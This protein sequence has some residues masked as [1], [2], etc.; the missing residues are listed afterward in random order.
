MTMTHR[1]GVSHAWPLRLQTLLFLFLSSSLPVATQRQM[2]HLQPFFFLCNYHGQ[3]QNFGLDSGQVVLSVNIEGNPI[4]YKPDTFYNVSISSSETFDSLLMTGLYT[5][6]SSISNSRSSSVTQGSHD[7]MCSIIHSQVSPRPMKTLSFIW[8]APP[9]GTGC[10][11][12][13]ATATHGQQLL[14]KD[15][16]IAQLCEQGAASPT[17][18]HPELAEVNTDSVLIRDDFDSDPDFNPNLWSTVQGGRVGD[19]CGHPVSGNSAIFCDSVGTRKMVS[20]PLNLTSAHML[21]FFLGEGSCRPAS[22]SD[23]DIII[24]YGINGCSRWIPIQTIKAAT[25]SKSEIHLVTLP[26]KARLVGTC[27]MFFQPSSNTG[28]HNPFLTTQNPTVKSAAPTTTLLSGPTDITTQTTPTLPTTAA[29]TTET[30][31]V[32]TKAATESATKQI[33]AIVPS[34]LSSA[35]MISATSSATMISATSSATT[36]SATS[37]ATTISATSPATTISATS[38][39]T[40]TSAK[41]TSV[42]TADST[43]ATSTTR[44][45]THTRA[46]T[47]TPI[48][49]E[50]GPTD[51][52]DI[53]ALL[54]GLP[55]VQPNDRQ[56]AA[57]P[58]ND[59]HACWTMDNVVIVNTAEPP[60]TLQENFDPIDPSDWLFFPG[61]QID[62]QCQAHG[63]ALI[64]NDRN[65]TS[66][67]AT[68]RDLNLDAQD[69]QGNA[70]LF[71][72]FDTGNTKL[73]IEG[74]HLGSSCGII[75]H[76]EA[77]ILDGPK[78]RRVCTDMFDI[79]DVDSAR[80][81][82]KFGGGPGCQADRQSPP[83][84]M[85]LEDEHDSTFMLD[86]L[87]AHAYLAHADLV[88]RTLVNST[89]RLRVHKKARF[90]LLQK[91]HAGRH[92]DVW[93]VDDIAL[94]P[95]LPL[96]S[97]PDADKVFQASLN[98]NCGSSNGGNKSPSIS[99][100]YSTD[101]GATW[102]EFYSPCL[103]FT[104]RNGQYNTLSSYLSGKDIYG[105][106][107][108][109]LPIPYSG[110]SPHSRF[111][112]R[113]HGSPAGQWALDDVFIGP[114]SKWCN[115]HGMCTESGCS[116]DYGYE[117]PVCEHTTSPAPATLQEAFEDSSVTSASSMLDIIGGSVSYLCGVVASGKAIVFNDAGR[118]SLTTTEI[119]T[120]SVSHV[121]FTL[122]VG[123]QSVT[124]SCPPPD[125]PWES[126]LLEMS[127]DGGITWALLGQYHTADYNRPMSL[128]TPIPDNLKRLCQFRW[129]QP[130]HSGQDK[131]VWAI[132]DILLLSLQ[133]AG[134]GFD[135]NTPSETVDGIERSVTSLAVEMMNSPDLDKRLTA[136]L[137]K[138]EDSF[139]GRM[140]SLKFSS[141]ERNG[142]PRTLQTKALRVGPGYIAQFDLVMGCGVPYNGHLDNRIYFQYSV[143]HGIS[144]HLVEDIC[145]PP[146]V[147]DTYT[148][149]SIY[150]HTKY[151]TWQT[152]SIWLSPTTWSQ[153]TKFQWIQPDWSETDVW[154]VSRVYI[155]HPCL[156]LCHGH[157][158]C[159]LGACSCHDGF[160]GESCTPQ[161]KL[162]SSIHADFGHRYDPKM[163]FTIRGGE[164]I[165]AD[166]GC[167][168]IL[169]GESLL[170]DKDG[171]RELLTKDMN[172][173]LVDFLQFWIQIG[174]ESSGSDRGGGNVI[175]GDG[176]RCSGADRR[177]ESIL[178]RYSNDGGIRWTL[179]A[180]LHH[181][182]YRTPSFVH[183]PLPEKAKSKHTRFQLWQPEH[184]GQG[185]DHWAVDEI[186]FGNYSK[187]HTLEDDF[188][189]YLDPIQSGQWRVITDGAT[190]K[191]CGRLQPSLVMSNQVNR[192]L[193]ISKDVQLKPGNV[194]Q[195]EINVD[196]GKLY[197]WN[198]PVILQYSH[199]NGHTWS[200]VEDPCYMDQECDGKLTEGSIYY[201][202]TH[203]Q[204][205]LVV[206]PISD[207]IAM[208][209]AIFQWWQQGGVD[210]SFSLDNVYIGPQCP[211]NCNRRGVCSHGV[212]HCL[213]VQEDGAEVSGPDCAPSGVTPQGMLDRFD[214][215]NMPLMEFWQHIRSGHLGRGCGVV[216]LGD[217]LY[218]GGD[219]T[220][221][222]Q[223][224]QLNTTEKRILEVSIKIGADRFSATCRPAS[225]RE[226]AVIIDF[227]RDN[228]ISWSV[229]RVVQ[230]S[231]EDV[232]SA[233]I[234]VNLP[235]EAKSDRTIF[236]FWQPL[237]L[238]GMPRAE[239]AIDSVLV[240]VNETSRPGF[241]DKFAEMMPSRY[242][243]FLA[244]AASNRETCGSPDSAL[245]FSHKDGYHIAETWDYQVTPTTFL[246]F[247]LALN[248]GA[249]THELY[250]IA[251]EYSIDH[252]Q[253]WFPVLSACTPPNYECAGYHLS[254]AYPSAYYGN[255]TRVTVA[256]PEGTVSPKT[257]FRWRRSG[258][259]EPTPIWAIDNVYLGSDCPWLC[260][261][262]GVCDQGK[263]LCDQ[264]FGGEICVSIT[265]LPATLKD[266]FDSM[267][268][269]PTIWGEVHGG[270][271]S[272]LCGAVVT[273]KSLTFQKNGL[274]IAVTHDMDSTLV[275]HIEFHFR[276]GCGGEADPWPRKHSVLLQY[277]TTGGILWKL[278]REIYFSNTS[279]PVFYSIPLPPG[280]KHN[281]TRF[282]FWQASS[283]G[284]QS[285]VWALD[286]LYIGPMFV[287]PPSLFDTFQ[288]GSPQNDQPGDP[289]AWIFVNNGQIDQFCDSHRRSYLSLGMG[290][291]SALVFRRYNQGQ[292]SAITTDLDL[293]PNSVLQFDINVG[294]GTAPRAKY[295]V[296]LEYSADGGSSWDLLGP[297]CV[298]EAKFAH[299]QKS[300]SVAASCFESYLPSTVF[301]A[302][303][304]SYWRRVVVPLNHIRVCGPVRFRWYQGKIPDT[305]FG[306][307][308]AID[309]VY[310]GPSCLEHCNGHGYCI[311][312]TMCKCDT[313]Y[314]EPLCV[315]DAPLP[316]FLK[317]DFDTRPSPYTNVGT[318]LG[319]TLS[320]IGSGSSNSI[321]ERNWNLWSSGRVQ[322]GHR[323][324]KVFTG[325]SFVQDTEGARALTTS[326]L[327]LSI[328]NSIQFHIRLGC[329]KTVSTTTLP[330]YLQ[331]SINGGIY[332]TTIEQFDFSPGQ[333]RSRYIA[334][335]LPRGSLTNATQIRWFQP[336]VS[337]HHQEEWAIDQV[338]TLAW[339]FTEQEHERYA[340]TADVKVNMGSFLQFDL[341]MGCSDTSVQS[342]TCFDLRLEYSHDLGTNW[343]LLFPACLP[344]MPECGQYHQSSTYRSDMFTDWNTV[345]VP[346]PKYTWSSQTRF[347]LYQAPGYS[348]NQNWA[349][350]HLYVGWNCPTFCQG[351]GHCQNSGCV[352]N[353][354][355]SGDGCSKPQSPLLTKLV[356][357]FSSSPKINQWVQTV[358]GAVVHPCR[359]LGAGEA[360]H[361]TGVSDAWLARSD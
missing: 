288:A 359:V 125:S 149:G 56:Q 244:D 213:D 247:D 3:P 103:P 53:N 111:R 37:P 276:Y 230:P 221:E 328:A 27:I 57:Q 114:C 104:C 14:F 187:L 219:G 250:D 119:N 171:A 66:T 154:A 286:N 134:S 259:K 59:F 18:L 12:F 49:T 22:K 329:N 174:G 319:P 201:T 71:E 128:S 351:H 289:V 55:V 31:T 183:L 223:T 284:E 25:T 352:C 110:L 264:G 67:Y 275:T 2:T 153:Q 140:R 121:Q 354:G 194:L 224:W 142:E 233:T 178:V 278:I 256:L 29:E 83:V 34:T 13:L 334:L 8:M 137:G 358:G 271:S 24:A 6:P 205:T 198:H 290:D 300:A 232:K 208:H 193:I 262:H 107:R 61:A 33:I 175:A 19:D 86:T 96:R 343:H 7:V 115:G 160:S 252:G 303:E 241:E 167:G 257:R 267:K 135:R 318:A 248:C 20:A 335:H 357:D 182:K 180:D 162:D 163:D 227:S 197:R 355:W 338:N 265:P 292:I 63:N 342:R 299:V 279:S 214:N 253:K 158:T 283:A 333:N 316:T 141:S 129:R 192:K 296:R 207:K 346:L 255:W 348:S 151:E 30:H 44:M 80:F 341:S 206:I 157:G 204:W 287:R 273:D 58:V 105:W 306:P 100:E 317:E 132:D 222:A 64:F 313:G 146:D 38:P 189:T 311:A 347:R 356:E 211:H 73:T 23:K 263:C 122:R 28:A 164:V 65:Q 274:R 254:S 293:G 51:P 89:M 39:Q 62:L 336:P 21:Q 161:N 298:Q 272:Q 210:H 147:C 60:P 217:S 323:C 138:L 305:D 120:T 266:D 144:W 297:D 35:T 109:T 202:G 294:C 344:S 150:H 106:D 87:Q 307:E 155:G 116:C 85:Y 261:G 340:S 361:F 239:W 102:H 325:S 282:R 321:D 118:R 191:Y 302:G 143:D 330:L 243:W 75:H 15:T 176:A 339:Y 26:L 295:P 179:L 301:Y 166:E 228:G 231:F 42:T 236:R 43:S 173:E 310:I 170:F 70:F 281:A 337:G 50:T 4:G 145:V 92:S 235:L 218:F 69:V 84:L 322:A 101:H 159:H 234:L 40:S 309:N 90:C 203:G 74:G 260:S 280:A 314:K 268:P 195:F 81:Y 79:Y 209:P 52:G 76:G 78:Q 326:N 186:M 199:D 10:V 16:S 126:V 237:G 238:G 123:S 242:N 308:W 48:L 216:D 46:A 349:V 315:P 200:L 332:W 82:L 320:G 41:E 136:N 36:I 165:H 95:L 258:I 72:N 269:R 225:S 270:S 127:C 212:C 240:G 350:R 139:C 133:D 156:E 304:S 177:S 54:G 113:Q 117:G 246:Q 345:T 91:S 291:N 226:E 112:V 277:S 285:S 168:I 196:C 11:N 124:S 45:R 152:V 249:L 245:E 94:L 229:L 169:A 17:I 77:L 251:L 327:D 68:T 97:K 312:G 130:Q 324:G 1:G 93:A 98:L 331:Y 353:P 148:S 5:A 99:V 185:T 131:D 360:M 190:G 188:N 184:S 9:T 32:T 220:R 215:Q 47:T 172:T 88:T 108:L 181:K